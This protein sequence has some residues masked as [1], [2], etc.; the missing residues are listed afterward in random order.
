MKFHK[1]RQNIKC[2][3]INSSGR[4]CQKMAQYSTTHFG[5]EATYSGIYDVRYAKI[6]LCL[7]HARE[8]GLKTKSL[9]IFDSYYINT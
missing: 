6:Y 5:A 4:Q 9:S 2:S 3:Y 8:D 7:Q 1:L